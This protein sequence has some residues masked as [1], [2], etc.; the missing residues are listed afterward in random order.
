MTSMETEI[1]FGPG[2]VETEREQIA[3]LR[4]ECDDARIK[5]RRRLVTHL[6]FATLVSVVTIGCLCVM[7]FGASLP[8][9]TQRN[10]MTLLTAIVSGGASFFAG[11]AAGKR[12]V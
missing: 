11:K 12:S 7:V 2:A 4:R 1:D 9:E 10:A 8:P 3:R 6:A 5:R